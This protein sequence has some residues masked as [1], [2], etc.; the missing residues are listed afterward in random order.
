MR[1]CTPWPGAVFSLEIN[2]EVK[3]LTLTKAG[4]VEN[5]L[6]AEPGTIIQ[7]DRKGGVVA[8]GGKALKLVEVLPPGKKPMSGSDYLNGCRNSLAG[9]KML[10]G[11]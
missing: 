11:K 8:C 1:A 10:A 2:G 7:A 3:S 4:I 9:E 6:D 5:T